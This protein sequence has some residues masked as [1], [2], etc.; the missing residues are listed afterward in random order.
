MVGTTAPSNESF[1][2]FPFSKYELEP[3]EIGL[4]EYPIQVYE[5]YNGGDVSAELEIDDSFLEELNCENYSCKI[6]ECLSKN[7]LKIPPRSSLE[8]KWRFSP[9]EAKTYQVC[10]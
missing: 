3:V 9:I 4:T 10:L 6:L 8:T 7:T 5:I 1:V 2:Y